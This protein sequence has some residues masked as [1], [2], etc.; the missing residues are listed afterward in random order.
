MSGPVTRIPRGFQHLVSTKPNKFAGKTPSRFPH[1]TTKFVQPYDRI[2]KWNIRPGDRVRLVAGKPK[3][4]Y[5]NEETAEEGYKVYTVKQVDLARN[6]VFLEGIHNLKSQIIQDRPY[7]WDQLS[8]TQKKSYEDQKNFI[9]IL[10]PVHYSNVQ[11]C[12]EDK[13]GPDSIYASR[14]KTSST[15]FNP[16]TQRIDWRRYATKLSGPVSAENEKAVRINWPKPEKEF[17]FPAPDSML[18]TPNTVTLQPTLN[19]SPLPPLTSTPLVDIFPQHINSPPPASQGLA[20]EYLRPHS[21]RN[22]EEIIAAD[23][24]MPLYLSEELAPRWAKGKMWKAYKARREAAEL[25]KKMIGKQAV[26]EWEAQGRDRG[27]K[28]VIDLEAVGLEGVFLR[29]RTRA[30]VRQA[31]E[32]EYEAANAEV[33]AEVAQHVREGRLYDPELGLWYNGRKA[34]K[35]ERKKERKERKE[36]K[37]LE[38]M[39]RLA[40]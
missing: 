6:W 30:E 13:D 28:A 10:R 17:V 1:P 38:R 31:A 32:G 12:L 22:T 15:H 19:L 2:R 33:Q 23:T 7:N 35:K 8:E 25:E 9:P 20:D 40:I 11:L 3:E 21:E 4:K 27:L 18:D 29:G 14:L 16:K 34:D 39:E 36:R 37:V 5:R 26:E 24:L